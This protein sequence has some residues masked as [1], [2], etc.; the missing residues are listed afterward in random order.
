MGIPASPNA[1]AA[2]SAA[3]TAAAGTVELATQAEVNTGTDTTR[4]VTPETLANYT[5]LGSNVTTP[6]L[7]ADLVL[8]GLIGGLVKV[9]ITPGTVADL[10]A[11]PGS[12]TFSDS[13]NLASASSSGTTISLDHDTSTQDAY[14]GGVFDASRALITFNRLPGY[15]FI[16][17]GHVAMPDAA[18]AADY[19]KGGLLIDADG[20][21]TRLM[22]AWLTHVTDRKVQVFHH[23]A[24]GTEPA[25]NL[26]TGV[27]E[28]AWTTGYWFMMIVAPDHSGICGYYAGA[29]G[30][31]PSITDYSWGAS[32]A[33]IF[34]KDDVTLQVGP[35]NVANKATPTGQQCDVTGIDVSYAALTTVT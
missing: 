27:S 8:Q 33:A 21:G 28:S 26:A 1:S 23:I 15:A 3:S 29:A 11:S 24:D 9:R 35:L 2:V 32:Q 25:Q 31:R 6:T 12:F 4:V 20:A 13:A 5:G 10:I 17:E 14:S 7:A 22:V 19:E 34:T 18:T 30:S 16:V